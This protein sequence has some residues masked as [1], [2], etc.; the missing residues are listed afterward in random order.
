[1]KS[2][3]HLQVLHVATTLQ[4]LCPEHAKLHRK[5]RD[6]IE[7]TRVKEEHGEMEIKRNT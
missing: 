7:N 3:A 6:S 4:Q 2:I 5:W 1:M